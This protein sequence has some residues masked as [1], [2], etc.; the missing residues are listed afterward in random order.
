V[1]D[2]NEEQDKNQTQIVVKEN[3]EGTKQEAETECIER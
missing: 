2:N 3:I 1:K